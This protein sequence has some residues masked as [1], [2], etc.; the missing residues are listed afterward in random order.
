MSETILIEVLK[1]P[2]IESNLCH[3]TKHEQSL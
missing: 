1:D 2:L 3:Q